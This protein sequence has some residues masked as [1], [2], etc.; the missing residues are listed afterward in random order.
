MRPACAPW[1]GHSGRSTRTPF[2][3]TL[4]GT[5][6]GGGGGGGED[7]GDIGGL[8]GLG[9]GLGGGGVGG[10]FGG[11][12]GGGEGGGGLVPHSARPS[13]CI[14]VV[15]KLGAWYRLPSLCIR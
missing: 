8:G 4:T 10:R 14:N 15:V 11:L 6:G 1:V 5:F 13:S 2:S 9:G 7:G 12:V 3:L